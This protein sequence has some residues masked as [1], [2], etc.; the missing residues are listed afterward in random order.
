MRFFYHHRQHHYHK[1]KKEEEGEEVFDFP[2]SLSGI[3]I[4]AMFGMFDSCCKREGNG[5]LSTS[6]ISSLRKEA[7]EKKGTGKLTDEVA[8]LKEQLKKS[9]EELKKRS[10]KIESVTASLESEHAKLMKTS[11]DIS[12]LQSKEIK[13]SKNEVAK[14]NKELEQLRASI[15]ES[16]DEIHRLRA[17]REKLS[18]V[19]RDCEKL[20]S[21]LIEERKK[22][23]DLMK[24]L[25]E[26]QKIIRNEKEK[27]MKMQEIINSSNDHLKDLEDARKIFQEYLDVNDDGATILRGL[28]N[29]CEAMVKERGDSR[30]EIMAASLRKALQRTDSILYKECEALFKHLGKGNCLDEGQLRIFLSILFVQYPSLVGAKLLKE[31][32]D[33][34]EMAPDRV[35]HIFWMQKHGLI[36]YNVPSAKE[37][38]M[39][40]SLAAIDEEIERHST[41]EGNI[42]VDMKTFLDIVSN[43]IIGKGK[44]APFYGEYLINDYREELKNKST[45]GE[46]PSE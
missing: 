27:E 15:K 19:E 20:K 31:I 39:K 24:D 35:S 43:C 30:N 22:Q 11:E 42:S 45:S 25:E 23:N 36:S 33:I 37:S 12:A 34:A 38:C 46:P 16:Q 14:K 1:K 21:S 4:R 3:V 8:W 29:I 28:H 13:K 44:K 6:S 5:T 10:Q 2:S 9:K 7:E 18:S 26:K 40:E 41:S 17:E 32:A